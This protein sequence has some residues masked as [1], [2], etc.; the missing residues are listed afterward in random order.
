VTGW[1]LI[2][3]AYFHALNPPLLHLAFNMMS[4]FY[5]GLRCERSFGSLPHLGTSVTS[6]GPCNVISTPAIR[7]DSR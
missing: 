2:A 7:R 3:S 4:Y 5:L 1:R 6:I